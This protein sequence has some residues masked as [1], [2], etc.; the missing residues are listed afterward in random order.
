MK[1]ILQLQI[2]L[3]IYARQHRPPAA[4]LAAPNIIELQEKV[5]QR[6]LRLQRAMRELVH[7]KEEKLLVLAKNRMRSV[8]KDKYMSKRKS[9]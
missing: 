8:I 5:L 2:L 4:Q 6:T 1:Q 7:K 9:N 3:Q